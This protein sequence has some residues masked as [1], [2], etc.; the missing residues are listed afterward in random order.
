MNSLTAVKLMLAGVILLS[1]I[2]VYAMHPDLIVFLPIDTT[3]FLETIVPL[4]LI[5]LFIERALEVFVTAWRGGNASLHELAVRLEKKKLAKTDKVSSSLEDA[6]KTQSDYKNNTRRV[7]LISGLAA[8]IL[9]SAFGVRALESFAD[10]DLFD[11]LS[12][13]QRDSFRL[14]DTIVTGAVLG[15]GADGIHRIVSVFTGFLDK[16]SDN[17]KSKPT[18]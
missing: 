1:L 12:D 8:G 15:G 3:Q 14:F 9:V 2:L 7:A 18:N 6:E 13:L 10:P 11:Q 16:T 17:L 5:A 4:F